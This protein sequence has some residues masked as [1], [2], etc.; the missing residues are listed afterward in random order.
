MMKNGMTSIEALFII[1]IAFI[2]MF[3]I[4]VYIFHNNDVFYKYQGKHTLVKLDGYYIGR[5]ID[6]DEAYYVLQINT[7][8]NI[9]KLIKVP[10]DKTQ[11][12]ESNEAFV[13]INSDSCIIYI[14][15]ANKIKDYG[16]ISKKENTTF[17]PIFLYGNR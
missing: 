15:D 4:G 10:I 16:V 1:L 7:N 9:T 5:I 3:G 14:P 17:I 13:E 11:I 12:K 8:N 2:G 6:N